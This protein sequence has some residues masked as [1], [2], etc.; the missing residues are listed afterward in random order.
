MTANLSQVPAKSVP[1]YTTGG[2][3]AVAGVG[4]VQLPK[5]AERRVEVENKPWQSHM[6]TAVTRIHF[7][8][9]RYVRFAP[10]RFTVFDSGILP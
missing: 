10:G 8:Y 9:R 7:T 1:R 5:C 6:K 3:V 4:A 2:P